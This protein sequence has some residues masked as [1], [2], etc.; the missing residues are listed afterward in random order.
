[1][2]YQLSVLRFGLFRVDSEAPWWLVLL[3]YLSATFAA[4]AVQEPSLVTTGKLTIPFETLLCRLADTSIAYVCLS[5]PVT[6]AFVRSTDRVWTTVALDCKSSRNPGQSSKTYFWVPA[7]AN[8]R[9]AL[10]SRLTRRTYVDSQEQ[11]RFLFPVSIHRVSSVYS[12]TIR[13][14]IC[15]KFCFTDHG[16]NA[17]GFEPLKLEWNEESWLALS[18]R[19]SR[20]TWVYSKRIDADTTKCNS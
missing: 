18:T 9:F 20:I 12:I 10:E 4:T 8:F 7:N 14:G 1:M 6:R 5:A 19:A 13:G 2:T 11:V 16:L 17:V 3:T 15:L